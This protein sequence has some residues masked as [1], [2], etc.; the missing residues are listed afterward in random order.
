MSMADLVPLLLETRIER[1]V[2]TR[3]EIQRRYRHKNR[4][5]YNAYRREWRQRKSA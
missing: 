5:K 1:R 4:A 2:L 3:T